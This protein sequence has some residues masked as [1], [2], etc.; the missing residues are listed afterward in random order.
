[1]ETTIDGSVKN[2]TSLKCEIFLNIE[3]YCLQVILG[4]SQNIY[5]PGIGGKNRMSKNSQNL[6]VFYH[7]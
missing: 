7:I 6:C 2:F 4:A 5:P 3:I 1:V